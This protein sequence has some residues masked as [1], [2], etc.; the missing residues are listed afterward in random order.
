VASRSLAARELIEFPEPDDGRVGDDGD[1]RQDNEQDRGRRG[2]VRMAD[3]SIEL[4]VERPR[5]V[6]QEDREEER[7]DVPEESEADQR[8]EGTAPSTTQATRL[9]SQLS[10]TPMVT[11]TG[12]SA[13]TPVPESE[14]VLD[15]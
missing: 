10:N 5:R 8:R 6:V 2:H 13:K 12:V 7:T 3:D 9:P 1:H 4:S 15:A 14:T 11:A